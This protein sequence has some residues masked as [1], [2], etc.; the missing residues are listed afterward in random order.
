MKS[1]VVFS[2]CHKVKFNVVLSSWIILICF[3]PQ[4]RHEFCSWCL[5]KNVLC[6]SLFQLFTIPDFFF[7]FSVYKGN[8][9]FMSSLS[10]FPV[11]F[12]NWVQHMQ[13][14]MKKIVN[15]S[16]HSRC[17]H[18]RLLF[19]ITWLTFNVLFI[20]KVLVDLR[21]YKV[22]G[23]PHHCWLCL[24]IFII[25]VDISKVRCI[26]RCIHWIVLRSFFLRLIR[27]FHLHIL[28]LSFSSWFLTWG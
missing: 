12:Q 3:R 5:G 2:C 23:S 25:K 21:I 22:I 8:A 18:S 28:I 24:R 16:C 9:F 6:L 19:K 13:I 4:C 27:C 14:I 17:G 26:I 11:C 20:C 7:N 10:S 15:K 1:A